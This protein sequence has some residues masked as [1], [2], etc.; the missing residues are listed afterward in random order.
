MC[1]SKTIFSKPYPRSSVWRQITLYPSQRKL[2]KMAEVHLR[3]RRQ[4]AVFAFDD[5]SSQVNLHGVYERQE[6][7]TFFAWIDVVRPGLF[8]DATALDLG[9]NIGNHSLFFS[10]YFRQV[11][12][13]EP[14]ERTFKVLSLNAELAANIT[15]HQV[16]LSDKAGTASFRV[17]PANIGAS[18]IVPPGDLGGSEVKLTTL[19]EATRGLGDIKLIK[20]DV[21]GHDFAALVGAKDT[22]GTHKPI[23]LFEQLAEDAAAGESVS[24]KL[25]KTYGYTTFAVIRRHPRAAAGMPGPLRAFVALAGRLLFGETMEI[26]VGDRSP[27][28]YHAMV[29]AIPDWLKP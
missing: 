24:I 16:G 10:D 8:R 25:L 11:H 20:V 28:G 2:T 4:L 12:A 15:C 9:A 21:E 13:F 23:I 6:L 27:E 26:E 3:T 14:N 29:I 5:V 17:N 7:E 18:R 19:D 1:A 22:I